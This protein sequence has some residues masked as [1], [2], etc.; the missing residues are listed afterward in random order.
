MSAHLS[1]IGKGAGESAKEGGK[2]KGGYL[3]AV[4]QNLL[5]GENK[6]LVGQGY[7]RKEAVEMANK[8]DKAAKSTETIHKAAGGVGRDISTPDQSTS[9]GSNVKDSDK[10]NPNFGN[11]FGY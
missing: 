2:K 4:A 6:T 5:S 11:Y 9:F 1:G 10:R 3:K 8:E 7:G